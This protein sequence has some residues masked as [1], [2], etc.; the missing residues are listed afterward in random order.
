MRVLRGQDLTPFD[1]CDPWLSKI[2]RE[3]VDDPLY[4]KL[5]EFVRD[6][7]TELNKDDPLKKYEGLLPE[8][9]L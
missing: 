3:G 5:K 9:S 2:S 6:K 1:S 4:M 7:P 8:I